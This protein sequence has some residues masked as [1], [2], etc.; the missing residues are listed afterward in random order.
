MDSGANS[1]GAATDAAGIFTSDFHGRMRYSAAAA[2][3]TAQPV[4]ATA[5]CGSS[6]ASITA[7]A[8]SHRYAS[9]LTVTRTVS[10]SQRLVSA[11]QHI[12][13]AVQHLSP[14]IHTYTQAHTSLTSILLHYLRHTRS[15]AAVWMPTWQH[16]LYST[17][18]RSVL[19][20]NQQR[21]NQ[22]QRAQLGRAAIHQFLSA[23]LS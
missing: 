13:Q 17:A 5:P 16:S 23:E 2:H 18:R 7:A 15:A 4:Q 9:L 6:A 8:H 20:A 22:L 21:G 10:G 3:P 14:Q 1:A 11:D 12:H 19:Q